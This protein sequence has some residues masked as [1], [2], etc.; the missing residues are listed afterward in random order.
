M[1][2]DAGVNKYSSFLW[3]MLYLTVIEHA[4]GH[5]D[6]YLGSTGRQL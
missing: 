1:K 3:S 4:V 5:Q 2:K 6:L